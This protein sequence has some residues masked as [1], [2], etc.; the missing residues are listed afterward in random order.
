M[1]FFGVSVLLPWNAVLTSLDFFEEKLP[2]LNPSSVIG[3][4]VN[5]LLVA[6][7][8]GTMIFGGRLSLVARISGLY[9]VVA[10]LMIM[11]PL[12]TEH[13]GDAFSID[14]VI[15][16]LFGMAAG[17]IQASTFAVGGMLPGRYMG[18]L[19]LGVG[20]SGII[21]NLLRAISLLAIPGDSYKGALMYFIIAAVILVISSIANYRF[22]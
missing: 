22:L 12:I 6:A 18:A 1:A 15:L 20:F 14:V 19:M 9:I 2:E 5:S 4:A 10:I 13:V 11:L 7:S 3:F 16:S 21:L 8:I 17:V